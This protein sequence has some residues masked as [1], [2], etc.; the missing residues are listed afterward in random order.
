MSRP[1]IIKL[2]PD[3][4]TVIWT[5]DQVLDK[6]ISGTSF[7]E[8]ASRISSSY[9]GHVYLFFTFVNHGFIVKIEQSTGNIINH[10]YLFLMELHSVY[11]SE[12]FIY[13]LVTSFGGYGDGQG[14][15]LAKYTEDLNLLGFGKRI[16][17]GSWSVA[18]NAVYYPKDKV[19]GWSVYDNNFYLHNTETK[20]NTSIW[21]QSNNSRARYLDADY[22]GNIWVRHGAGADPTIYGCYSRISGYHMREQ[23]FS[24]SNPLMGIKNS[25]TQRWQNF[26]PKLPTLEIGIVF[27]NNKPSESS[28]VT[29]PIPGEPR[30]GSLLILFVR[31]APFGMSTNG[32]KLLYRLANPSAGSLSVFVKEDHGSIS[33]SATFAA[34]SGAFQVSMARIIP[35]N[36]Q[37]IV[38]SDFKIKTFSSGTVDNLDESVNSFDVGDGEKIL[39]SASACTR[40]TT[41]TNFS[42]QLP[43]ISIRNIGESSGVPT[44]ALGVGFR[45]VTEAGVY[46][47][48]LDHTHSGTGT[49]NH[50]SIGFLAESKAQ[51]FQEFNYPDSVEIVIKSGDGKLD[52]DFVSDD[53]S[54]FLGA[55]VYINEVK[56]NG[57]LIEALTY[58]ATGL[59]N[60]VK[61]DV[62]VELFYGIVKHVRSG[63]EYAGVVYT[64]FSEYTTNEFPSDWTPRWGGSTS[65]YIVKADSGYTGGKYLEFPTKGSTGWRGVSWDVMDSKTWRKNI[66]IQA[67]YMTGSSA[68]P[69]WSDPMFMAMASGATGGDDGYTLGK[70]NL[71]QDNHALRIVRYSSG[72]GSILAWHRSGIS[73]TNGV[74]HQLEMTI[75]EFGNYKLKTWNESSSEPAWQI[76]GTDPSPLNVLG[77]VGLAPFGQGWFRFD[78]IKVIPLP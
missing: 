9:S 54:M 44:R 69:G 76:E 36:G 2:S 45:K 78:W 47:V 11:I 8:S 64:D 59:T 28:S 53:D 16:N 51:D 62:R 72:T 38:L 20:A 22:E 39:L 74:F 73:F 27:S 40:T 67:R 23:M 65:D 49:H 18:S 33:G 55:D 1:Q 3:L 12:G 25:L 21:I 41:N 13:A 14:A 6:V 19:V 71:N 75:D 31:N 34:V 43:T 70:R 77:W 30:A 63:S 7:V 24:H 29:L 17:T 52:I 4:G 5:S 15:Y 60:G 46:K 50:A 32:F 56:D 10:C 61:Y 57:S 68:S 48:H 58:S 66:R 26:E 35:V 42:E 37:K